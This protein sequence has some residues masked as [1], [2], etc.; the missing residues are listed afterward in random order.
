MLFIIVSL[1]EYPPDFSAPKLPLILMVRVR[2]SLVLNRWNRRVGLE[3]VISLCRYLESGL[4]V[5]GKNRPSYEVGSLHHACNRFKRKTPSWIVIY[6]ALVRFKYDVNLQSNKRYEIK[7]PNT[8][9]HL[10]SILLSSPHFLYNISSLIDLSLPNKLPHTYPHQPPPIHTPNLPT[11]HQP[12][13]EK[14][15]PTKTPPKPAS[16][17]ATST[18]P[19]ALRVTS[20]AAPSTL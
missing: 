3:S 14:C 20:P 18:T 17:P 19:S 5:E 7:F 4:A 12:H 1:L 2:T 16:F 6:M 13:T 11:L 8:D 15:R 9:H 10:S